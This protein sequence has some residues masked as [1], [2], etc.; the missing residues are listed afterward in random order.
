MMYIHHINNKIK[1]N[2]WKSRD[3][4]E[5]ETDHCEILTAIESNQVADLPQAYTRHAAGRTALRRYMSQKH[6]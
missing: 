6:P 5:L 2:Q 1:G 3:P 4:S